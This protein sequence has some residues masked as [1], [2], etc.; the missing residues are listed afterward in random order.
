MDRFRL[1]ILIKNSIYSVV[2]ATWWL[3]GIRFLVAPFSRKARVLIYHKVN[4]HPANLLSVSTGLFRKQM[5]YLTKHYN[6]IPV[7]EIASK[8]AEGSNF[9]PRTIAIT[10]DDGYLD[11]YT[12]AYPILAEL[13]MP[14][15][16]F[17]PAGYMGRGTILPHDR[18]FNHEFNPL[19]DWD[20]ITRMSSEKIAFGGHTVH[21]TVLTSVDDKTAANEITG[22]KRIIENKLGMEAS[23]FAYPV[24]TRRE[25]N[26]EHVALVE[27]AGYKAAF[28]GVA[29]SIGPG[30]PLFEIPRCN[31]EPESFFVF[32]RVLDGSMDFVRIKDSGI[33]PILK[34][35]FN[36]VLGTPS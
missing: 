32:K 20:Q 24:G 22:S 34:D 33:F 7:S 25:Y 14:A 16:I 10:F 23:F 2:A 11:N 4:D 12:N 31:V 29:G 6:V 9:E 17:I 13:N 5:E 30:T 15:T 18:A 19:L 27:K 35:M 28:T 21:H 8:V 26:Q 36:R 3:A 1:K